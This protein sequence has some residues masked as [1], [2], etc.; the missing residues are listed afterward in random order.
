MTSATVMFGCIAWPVVIGTSLTTPEIGARTRPR[1]RSASAA[2]SEASAASEVGLELVLVVRRDD[3]ALDQLQLG[4]EIGLPLLDQ[5]LGLCDLRVARLV[6]ERGEHV[7]L[8]APRRR[9]RP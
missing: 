2:A 9:D 6:G 3:A 5:R 1:S 8:P 4:V 7:A